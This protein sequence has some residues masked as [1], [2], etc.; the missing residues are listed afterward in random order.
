MILF[1]ETVPLN[2]Q[3]LQGKYIL[4]QLLL[5]PRIQNKELADAIA[6]VNPEDRLSEKSR[7]ETV[8]DHVIERIE[9]GFL[10]DNALVS[11]MRKDKQKIFYT[12]LRLFIQDRKWPL[13]LQHLGQE[14]GQ[15]CYNQALRTLQ[16][17]MQLRSKGV[18][19][20]AKKTK[21]GW[22]QPAWVSAAVNMT[23]LP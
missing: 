23:K 7:G 22:F 10:N 16:K 21:I 2:P 4:S 1:F 11:E 9:K 12:R 8:L 14:G 17:A 13:N 3:K 19:H 6:R 20:W 15:E 18:V 5:N